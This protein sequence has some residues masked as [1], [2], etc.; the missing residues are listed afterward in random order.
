MFQLRGI[1]ISTQ[2]SLERTTTIE[3]TF[4]FLLDIND[5]FP[6]SFPPT[7]EAYA[8]QKEWDK[9]GFTPEE[10]EEVLYELTRSDPTLWESMFDEPSVIPPKPP[11]ET[12]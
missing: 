8:D 3:D 7:A 6:I 9:H 12:L 1:L 11:S 4:L 2:T 10:E 5:V